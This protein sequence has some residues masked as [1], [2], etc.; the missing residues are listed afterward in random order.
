MSPAAEICR[1]LAALLRTGASPRAALIELPSRVAAPIAMPSLV[2]CSRRAR[3][4]LPLELVVQTLEGPFGA[5]LGAL[6]S[7]LDAVEREGLDGVASLDALADALVERDARRAAARAAGAGAVASARLIAVLPLLLLPVSMSGPVLEK[8]YVLVSIAAG[9]ALG[10]VGYRWLTSIVPAPPSLDSHEWLIRDL[11][12][13][14]RAGMSLE[15][16]IEAST[17]GPLGSEL[18]RIGRRH[19]LGARLAN[20]LESEGGPFCDLAAAIRDSERS[21]TPVAGALERLAEERRTAAEMAFRERTGKAPVKMVVPLTLCV[22]P[23]FVLMG[24]VPL[25]EGFRSG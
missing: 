24:V 15:Q 12:A 19:R 13:L 18:G 23:A 25:I 21:G 1:R 6:L 9:L 17:S 11:A 20:A 7:R 3:L 5:D 16:G 8:P 2:E 4:G 14:A 22:L 10:L